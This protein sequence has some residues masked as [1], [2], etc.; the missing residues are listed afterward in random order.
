MNETRLNRKQKNDLEP[1]LGLFFLG[2]IINIAI[3]TE[4]IASFYHLIAND[5]NWNL[6]KLNS[7]I[8]TDYIKQDWESTDC[9]NILFTLYVEPSGR[10]R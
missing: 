7:K 10:P 2:E 8:L 3:L 9:C 5:I 6:I 4:L 1:D